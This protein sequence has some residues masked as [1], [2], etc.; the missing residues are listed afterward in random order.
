MSNIFE[1]QARDFANVPI[2]RRDVIASIHLENADDKKFWDPVFQKRCPGNYNYIAQSKS[3]SGNNTSGCKQCLNYLQYI[4][5]HFFI[6]IDS[7]IHYLL[8][9][10]DLDSNHFVCQTYT[11]SW[12]NHYC[13]AH[14]LMRRILLYSP[15]IAAKFDFITFLSEYSRMVFK[16]LLLLIN[17]LKARNSYFNLK[18]FKNCLVR[19]CRGEELANN[20][21]QIIKRISSNFEPYMSSSYARSIDYDAE[22]AYCQTIQITE[23][24]AYLHVRGHN[25]FSL[26][27]SI[28]KLLCRGTRYSFINDILLKELPQNTYWEI[29]KVDS[30]IN[31]ILC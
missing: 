1:D 9:K 29:N 24:N 19:Q 6:A 5:N 16:P 17:C 8:Q 28:G 13:E 25:L 4:N 22:I 26:I 20:G 31:D 7:D 11:Y 27:S 30:D 12:E 15:E 18:Q 23:D 14:S 3:R 21:E 2:I 10:P